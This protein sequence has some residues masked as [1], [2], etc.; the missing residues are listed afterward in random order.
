MTNYGYLTSNRMKLKKKYFV[1][2]VQE[3]DTENVQKS[4]S[5]PEL[6]RTCFMF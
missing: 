1:K 4:Y 3:V 6:I 5:L 2:Y